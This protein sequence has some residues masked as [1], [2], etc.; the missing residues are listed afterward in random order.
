MRQFGNH[1]AVSRYIS[2]PSLFGHGFIFL[3]PLL[4]RVHV[5]VF[6][7]VTPFRSVLQ[8][9]SGLYLKL[10]IASNG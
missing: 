7:R 4:R 9:F 1:D 5:I 10:V 8:S 3:E 6:R 2:I